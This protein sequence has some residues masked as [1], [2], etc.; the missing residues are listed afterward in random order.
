MK[1][2]LNGD[3]KTIEQLIQAAD[4]GNAEATQ[5]IQTILQEEQK[6]NTQVAKAASVIKQLL[7]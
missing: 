1:S 3:P 2:V 4:Q 5:L 6:G 7:N